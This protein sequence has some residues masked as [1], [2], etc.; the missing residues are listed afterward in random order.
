MRLVEPVA[1]S[2]KVAKTFKENA[3]KINHINYSQNG[4][5]L[6]SSSDDDQIVIY[7]CVAGT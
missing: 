2:F 4:D 1:K 6:I 3:D 7:D 5:S